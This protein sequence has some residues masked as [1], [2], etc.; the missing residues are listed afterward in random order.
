MVKS[1]FYLI[2][3]DGTPIYVGF[4]N[5]DI[6][7]RFSEHKKEKDFS[8]YDKVTVEKIDEI[9]YM[10]TWDESTL[11]KNANEVSVREAQ[12]IIKYNTQDSKYQKAIDG[13]QVWTYKKW[14]VNTNKDNPKFTGMSSEDIEKYLEDSIEISRFMSNFVKHM[15]NPTER[16]INDFTNH[17]VSPEEQYMSGFIQGIKNPTDSYMGSFVSTMQNPVSIYM[18]YFINNL[19]NYTEVYMTHFINHMS[20]LSEDYMRNFV[21]GM[22]EP[23]D[24]Y[25][26]NFVNNMYCTTEQYMYNMINHM[27]IKEDNN[28]RN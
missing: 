1:I 12:L 6:K 9:D 14:F 23:S 15:E 25:M 20:D 24:K 22:M 16:Y 5:R 17:M 7:Q 3:G 10:F 18:K 2:R 28:D 4:T 13:G 26:I 8:D 11:Y 27:K 19:K 21:R